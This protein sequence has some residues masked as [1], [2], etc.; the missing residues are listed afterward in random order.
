MNF[1]SFKSIVHPQGYGFWA[2]PDGAFTFLGSIALTL[3][4]V[5]ATQ[6]GDVVAGMG[7]L[8]RTTLWDG[9]LIRIAL[10]LVLTNAATLAITDPA[11]RDFSRTGR[12]HLWIAT[13]GATF[14]VGAMVIWSWP[15]FDYDR[16]APLLDGTMRIC[17]ITFYVLVVGR[18]LRK[19]LL[20]RHVWVN[21]E[22]ERLGAAG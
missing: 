8:W 14:V 5:T 22:I 10:L 4:I 21:A 13:V 3:T 16:D 18:A 20:A 2:D 17:A 9:P 1:Q 7:E 19:Q 11:P 15:G 12:F 6:M